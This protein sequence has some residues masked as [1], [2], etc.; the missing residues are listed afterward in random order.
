MLM[1]HN[2]IILVLTIYSLK[3]L[4]QRT[5]KQVYIGIEIVCQHVL[6]FIN[7]THMDLYLR[8]KIPK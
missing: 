7:Q 1:D 2:R 6:S 4:C 5:D 8:N 3:L